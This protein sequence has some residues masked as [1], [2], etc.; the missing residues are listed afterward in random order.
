MLK[1]EDHMWYAQLNS[2]LTNYLRW[3]WLETT[4]IL[5]NGFKQHPT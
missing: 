1:T 3:H 4:A 2:L 5:K